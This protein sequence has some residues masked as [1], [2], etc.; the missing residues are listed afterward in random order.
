MGNVKVIYRDLSSNRLITATEAATREP[1]T[2]AEEIF[3]QN[4][5]TNGNSHRED[6]PS[7]KLQERIPLPGRGGVP[8]ND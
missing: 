7:V 6:L 2:W 4:L 1:D 8:N 5:S 3:V